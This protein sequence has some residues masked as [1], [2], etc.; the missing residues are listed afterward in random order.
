ML[1]EEFHPGEFVFDPQANEAFVVQEIN[2]FT[3]L[4]LRFRSITSAEC[5]QL[6][7][8]GHYKHRTLIRAER[9]APLEGLLAEYVDIVRP[10]Y[11][12]EYYAVDVPGAEAVFQPLTPDAARRIVAKIRE[13]F[14]QAPDRPLVYPVTGDASEGYRPRGGGRGSHAAQKRRANE[15]EKIAAIE[16]YLR[17]QE[18]AK[19]TGAGNENS[20]GSAAS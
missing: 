11:N 10:D 2:L 18:A 20:D 6:H 5:I 12:M 19:L 4:D 8:L 3:N 15:N 16:A 1:W 9:K 17:E 14:E 13:R 7:G